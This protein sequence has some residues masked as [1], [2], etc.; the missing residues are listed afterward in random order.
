M[1]QFIKWAIMGPHLT[2]HLG[3]GPEG[4]EHWFEVFGQAF[5]P[6]AAK[7]VI[8]GV[9]EME[10]VKMKSM[11]ELVRWRDEK[12]AELLKIIYE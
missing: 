8:E 2:Y 7:K 4:I 10:I 5:S 6:S 12:L 1:C 3:G 11:E 9:K